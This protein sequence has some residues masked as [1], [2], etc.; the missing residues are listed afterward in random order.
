MPPKHKKHRMKHSSVKE[1]RKTYA[2]L[3]SLPPIIALLMIGIISSTSQTVVIAPDGVFMSPVKDTS[4]LILS[5]TIF[6]I[7]YLVFIGLL[8][9]DSIVKYFV[10]TVKK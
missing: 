4:P 9:K 10:S 2:F 3:L 1:R 5:L 8:F 6:I 7:G